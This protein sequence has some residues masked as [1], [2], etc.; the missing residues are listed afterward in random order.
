MVPTKAGEEQFQEGSKF[1]YSKSQAKSGL[2]H[3]H[4]QDNAA[5]TTALA[6]LVD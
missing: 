4:Q 3:I 2:K 6:V 5:V 1:K